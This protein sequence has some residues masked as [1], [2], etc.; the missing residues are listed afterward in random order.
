MRLTLII[1]YWIS[2]L[3]KPLKTDILSFK[4]TTETDDEDIPWSHTDIIINGK[5]LFE[6]L[7]DYE[8]SEARRTR[9]D[10]KL[11]GKY[12]G[13]DPSDLYSL[14]R[15]TGRKTTDNY[16]AWQCSDCRSFCSSHLYCTYKVGLFFVY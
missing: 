9:T 2:L 4:I 10:T 12:I 11:V 3:I 1:K 8:V 7:R 14:Y 16:S 5:S 13:I 6:K 15:K